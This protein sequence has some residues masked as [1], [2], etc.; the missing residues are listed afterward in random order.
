MTYEIGQKVTTPLGIG[1]I[2]KIENWSDGHTQFVVYIK[3]IFVTLSSSQLKPYKTP[4]ERLLELGYEY[5]EHKQGH[6][7]IHRENKDYIDVDLLRSSYYHFTFKHERHYR[8]SALPSGT[9]LE[10]SRILTEYL[11]WLE[12]EK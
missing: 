5:Q 8:V 1:E 10:L 9:T 11:E 7:Y 12:E 2:K 3:G 6:R 4:H